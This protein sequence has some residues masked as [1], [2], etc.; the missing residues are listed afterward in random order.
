MPPVLTFR[1]VSKQYP[2]WKAAGIVAIDRL[3][4]SIEPGEIVGFLGPNG[5]GKTTA[6]HIALG[7]LKPTSGSGQLFG[8][9]LGDATAREKL[10]FVSDQPV[11][12]P[13]DAAS[14]VS[15]AATFNNRSASRAAIRDLLALC[16]LQDARGDV[17]KFSRGMQQRLALAQALVHKP[18]LLILDEPISALDPR[19]TL[20][21]LALLRKLRNEGT[22]VLL[23]SHQLEAVAT[24]ADRLLLLDRGKLLLAGRTTDLLRATGEDVVTFEGLPHHATLSAPRTTQ[25]GGRSSY[26]CRHGELERVIREAWAMGA[27]LV[28]VHSA[29]E[30]LTEL[31]LRRTSAAPDTGVDAESAA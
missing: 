25:D 13:G 1:E 28:E 17:R 19:S 16:G 10:G 2:S 4:L 8:Q 5:A 29:T 11:F 22:A 6:L 27:E 12:F 9:P 15:M 3:T 31:F 14:A 26:R 24:I 30:S 18:A 23:S 20:T 7:F 21:V